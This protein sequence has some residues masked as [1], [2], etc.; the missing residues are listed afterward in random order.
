MTR[1][2]SAAVW[3]CQ[4]GAAVIFAQTL[5]FK[6]T[7]APE[8]RVVFA[9]LGGRP[10]ATITGLAELACAVLLVI[11]RT[12]VL[13]ALLSLGVIA[14]AIG[15]HVFVIGIQVVDP[16]TGTGDGGLLFGLAVLVAALAAVV[17]VVRRAELAPFLRWLR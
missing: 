6:F 5:Y 16:E 13:G 2:S 3:L 17:L 12:A 7:W 10:A 9:N 15:T 4:I 1:K 8:T 11:P 14:G